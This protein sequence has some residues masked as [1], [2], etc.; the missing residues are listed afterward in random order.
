MKKML[1][2]FNPNTGAGKLKNKLMDIICLF[3]AAG[4]QLIIYPTQKAGD[5]RNIVKSRAAACQLVVCCGGDGTLNE[6]VDGLMSLNPRPQLG[7]IPGGTTNDF[8]SSMNL[9]K[10]NMLAAATAIVESSS[11]HYCDIGSFNKRSFVYVAAFGAFSEVAYTTPQGIKNS[12]GYFAYLLEAVQHLPTIVP[13]RA[14]YLCEQGEFEDDYLFGMVANST[15]VGG[16]PFPAKQKI[17]LDDGFFEVI[18]LKHPR[19]LNDLRALS[20]SLLSR[21]INSHLLTV[22]RVKE[23]EFTFAKP[24]AW[25]LDGEFGG[26]CEKATIQVHKHA[27]SFCK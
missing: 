10:A 16:F 18:L 5:A 20:A 8:A 3:S 24:A 23:I 17:Q 19:N 14:K 1:F 9:P 7:Y 12:L 2:V 27:I 22:L 6:V 21:K 15:S 26:E 4:Y 11:E 25:T 13:T